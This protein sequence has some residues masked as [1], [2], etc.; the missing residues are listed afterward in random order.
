MAKAKF[1]THRQAVYLNKKTGRFASAK[2]AK[3]HPTAVTKKFVTIKH[4]L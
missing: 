4:A 3:Q 2:Y 1:V